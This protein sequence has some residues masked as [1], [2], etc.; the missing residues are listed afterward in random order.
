VLQSL[1][2]FAHQSKRVRWLPFLPGERLSASL[3]CMGAYPCGKSTICK[4]ATQSRGFTVLLTH[5]SRFTG[6]EPF[7]SSV[8]LLRSGFKL[9]SIRVILPIIRIESQFFEHRSTVL[10]HLGISPRIF[11]VELLRVHS[12]LGYK[13]LCAS[14]NSARLGIW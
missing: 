13:P 7:I 6:D 5:A 4:C 2:P 8:I 3:P 9:I 10:N 12:Y 14:S 1:G 11:L